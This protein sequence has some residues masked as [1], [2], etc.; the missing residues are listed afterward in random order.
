MR[1]E[2]IV[3]AAPATINAIGMLYD[4]KAISMNALR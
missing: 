4:F 1:S 3:K 2:A